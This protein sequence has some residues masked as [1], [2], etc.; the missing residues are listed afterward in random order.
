MHIYLFNLNR[1]NI[2]TFVRTYLSWGKEGESEIGMVRILLCYFLDFDLFQAPKTRI[3]NL[4]VVDVCCRDCQGH[5]FLLSTQ[6]ILQVP[7]TGN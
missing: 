6:Y 2:R 7:K 5:P 3:I 1:H 4:A